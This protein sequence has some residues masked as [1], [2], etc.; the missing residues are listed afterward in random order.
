M[1]AFSQDLTEIYQM[2]SLET[3]I[4]SSFENPTTKEEAISVISKIE[5]FNSQEY[6]TFF[7]DLIDK[8]IIERVYE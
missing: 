6:D 2:N 4:V 8:K 1:I 3:L 5:G 7:Q